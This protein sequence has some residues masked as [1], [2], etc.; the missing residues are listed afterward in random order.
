MRA[1]WTS[2]G[3][4]RLPAAQH[5]EEALT[6]ARQ[7]RFGPGRAAVFHHAAALAPGCLRHPAARARRPGCSARRCPPGCAAARPAASSSPAR[8]A[9]GLGSSSSTWPLASA[10]APGRRP[11]AR[12]RPRST[13]AQWGRC[14]GFQA[15]QRQQL[16]HQPRG[17]V[18]AFQRGLQAWRAR[19]RRLR[20]RHLGLGADGG[21]RRAQLVRGV[22]GEAAL[23]SISAAMRLE[24][25]VQGVS[26][27]CISDGAFASTTG[28]SACGSTARASCAAQ[29]RNGAVPR[30]HGPPRRQRQQR[31]RQRH[32]PQRAAQHGAQDRRARAEPA[33]PRRPARRARRLGW[34]TRARAVPSMRTV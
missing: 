15:R 3:R 1:R 13:G 8:Q 10:A 30:T 32:R 5:A 24:Q 26:M 31:Q 28:S 33:R 18:A 17:A 19:R 12:Q 34:R 11:P 2:P 23:A 16:L 7:L 6:Q 20:Q 14:A 21:D 27:G 29:R 4:C 22:G 9:A 25:A